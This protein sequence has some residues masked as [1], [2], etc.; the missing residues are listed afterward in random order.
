MDENGSV[1]SDRFRSSI[2]VLRR[3]N[4]VSCGLGALLLSSRKSSAGSWR[5]PPGPLSGGETMPSRFSWLNSLTKTVDVGPKL[6]LSVNPSRGM[7]CPIQPSETMT[8]P[9]CF[10]SLKL[11]SCRDKLPTSHPSLDPLMI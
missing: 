6:S 9:F 11:D 4:S 2:L 1:D 7:L 8:L 10:H 5:V 3:R